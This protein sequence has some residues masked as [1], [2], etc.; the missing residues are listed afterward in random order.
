MITHR[1]GKLQFVKETEMNIK[2]RF[3]LWILNINVSLIDH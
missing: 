3:A 2:A 1:V